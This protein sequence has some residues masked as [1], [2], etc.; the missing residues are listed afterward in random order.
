MTSPTRPGVEIEVDGSPVVAPDDGRSLLD[1]LRDVCG[2]TSV[3]DGC[4]PQGQCG[5]CTVLVDGQPRVA[6]VTPVRRVRGRRITTIDGLDPE[7]RDRWGSSFTATGASQCGFCTPGIICRFEGLRARAEPH[8]DREVAARALR[9]H[10]CR[11]T[12]WQTVVDAWQA[13]PTAPM[14]TPDRDGADR[15]A[16]LEGRSPQTSGP[17][18]ALGGGGFADDTAPPDSL[19]AVLSTSGDWVVG[20][21]L[22]EARAT[23]GKVQGRRTSSD[24]EPPITVPEGDFDVTLQ[25]TWVEPGYLE[26]D[27][28]WCAPGGQ[29]ASP[30]GNGGAFGGKKSSPVAEVARRLADRHGRPVRAL[31]SREDAVR[32]GPKRPPLAGGVNRDGTGVIRVARTPGVEEAISS[33]APA[34][35]IEQVDVVGPP[36]S[37][38]IRGAGWVEASA[39][40]AAAR[41]EV[42]WISSPDGGSA[43][44]SIGPD[45]SITVRVRAGDVLDET[46]LRSYCTG[47]THMALSLV[48]SESL[49]VDEDGEVHD[50][51]VRSFGI[52]TALDTPAIEIVVEPDDRE[53]VNG[54]DAVFAAVAAA[55]WIDSGLPPRWPT[56]R[57]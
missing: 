16:S 49:S 48:T 31:W 4:S 50:L 54:S 46:V 44:A 21:T 7:I 26:T 43:T 12:G 39:M 19:V 51:T 2:V 33:V 37:T 22:F 52:L 23:A 17:H 41:G 30:L 36:T 57:A 25:T 5:C 18:V 3:K 35:V 15:R 6:C 14:S 56:G 13:F 10:L 9:A 11:C 40:M 34:V 42:G 8:D 27:A 29:P 24:W 32:H 1:L 38:D 55:V 53:P 28:S 20:E 45:G 47:A